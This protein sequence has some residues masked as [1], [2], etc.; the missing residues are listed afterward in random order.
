LVTI[1]GVL[2][3]PDNSNNNHWVVGKNLEEAKLVA[4]KK[5]NVDISKVQLE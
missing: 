4:A 5:F 1:P 3:N 2:D